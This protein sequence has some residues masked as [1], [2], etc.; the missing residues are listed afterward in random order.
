[1]LEVTELERDGLDSSSHLM[2]LNIGTPPYPH[3]QS[4]L[5]SVPALSS[6]EYFLLLI[7]L[8]DLGLAEDVAALQSTPGMKPSPGSDFLS[9]P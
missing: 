2:T 8:Q 3:S 5:L 6:P 9:Y 1:M 4:R 7:S